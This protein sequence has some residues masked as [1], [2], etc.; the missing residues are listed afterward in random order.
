MVSKME[1]CVFTTVDLHK[2][3]TTEKRTVQIRDE[4]DAFAAAAR[5]SDLSSV[6]PHVHLLPQKTLSPRRQ[7]KRGRSFDIMLCD[8]H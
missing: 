5:D 6:I 7:L 1:Q 8:L 2:I 3:K 4:A